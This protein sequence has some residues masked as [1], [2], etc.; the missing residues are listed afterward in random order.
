MRSGASLTHLCLILPDK[1][2]VWD[3]TE[4][5]AFLSTM[6]HTQ[7]LGDAKAEKAIFKAID[8]DVW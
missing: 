4:W 3:F 7:E 1:S 8:K 2:G 5:K 6:K